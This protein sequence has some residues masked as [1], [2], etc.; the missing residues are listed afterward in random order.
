[1]DKTWQIKR[2]IGD[3]VFHLVLPFQ[4]LDLELVIVVRVNIH[5]IRGRFDNVH[6]PFL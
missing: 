4:N 2:E 6:Y 1:M 3:S 5:W